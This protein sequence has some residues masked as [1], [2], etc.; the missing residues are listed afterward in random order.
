MLL[1]LFVL[2]LIFTFIFPPLGVLLFFLWVFVLISKLSVGTGKAVIKTG[3][4]VAKS[5]TTMKC[6]HCYSVIDKNSSVCKV[7]KKD[8]NPNTMVISHSK[9]IPRNYNSG[10]ANNFDELFVKI[11]Q[12]KQLHDNEIYNDDEFQQNKLKWI[13]ELKR[14]NFE[15]ESHSYLLKL[16]EIMDKNDFSEDEIKLIKNIISGQY[17]RDK[18]KEKQEL[19]KLKQEKEEEEIRIR[20]EE[21]KEYFLNVLEKLKVIILNTAKKFKKWIRKRENKKHIILFSIFI[22]ITRSEE[23]RVGK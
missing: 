16:T 11:N 2:A 5:V 6:P 8:I 18:L 21:R 22:T 13:D 1:A 19:Q 17:C 12:I 15:D 7:C 4:A 14:C 3:S 23:R 20:R 9:D 10:Q